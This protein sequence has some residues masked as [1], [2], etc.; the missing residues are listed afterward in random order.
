MLAIILAISLFNLTDT[1]SIKGTQNSKQDNPIIISPFIDFSYDVSPTPWDYYP[2]YYEYSRNSPNLSLGVNFYR[3]P[4]YIQLQLA[5]CLNGLT[6]NG[7]FFGI[8][9]LGIVEEIIKNGYVEMN[10][11]YTDNFAQYFDYNSYSGH[12][13]SGSIGYYHM[14]IPIDTLTST[15]FSG[16]VNLGFINNQYWDPYWYYYPYQKNQ[17]NFFTA[18]EFAWLTRYIRPYLAFGI[19]NAVDDYNYIYPRNSGF[20]S[21]GIQAYL[22]NILPYFSGSPTKLTYYKRNVP[23]WDPHVYK[24]NIYLYP[25]TITQVKVTLKPNKDCKIIASVPE[26]KNGWNVLVDQNGVIDNQF[27]YLFYE[28]KI[29][30]VPDGFGWSVA[31]AELWQFL[32]GKMTEYGFNEKE[33]K[34]FVDYWQEHLPKSEFYEIMP[35]IN[36]EI[37]KEFALA[38]EPKPEAVLRVWFY[39]N[40]TNSKKDLSPPSI[41]KFERKGFTVIEWGVLLK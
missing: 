8:A 33:I 25:E 22:T 4:L 5:N 37:E 24:P 20:F 39:I 19:I 32:P 16:G 38:I 23:W 14:F 35:V 17:T 21:I 27:E 26:H 18:V 36:Q 31:C 11:S 6:D 1:I 28:G 15:Y 10:F 30:N 40:P 3:R 29:K 7:D 13:Y 9:K 41:P 2:D 34:D 12:S